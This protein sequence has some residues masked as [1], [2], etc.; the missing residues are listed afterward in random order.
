M[1]GIVNRWM[2]AFFALLFGTMGTAHAA[3]DAAVITDLATSRTDVV[4]LGLL[5]FTIAVGIK[6]YKWLRRAL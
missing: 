4:A 1:K 5:V 6:L 2:G 3:L